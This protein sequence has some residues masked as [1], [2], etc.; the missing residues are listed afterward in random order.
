[1]KT[2]SA[3]VLLF[4]KTGGRPE[5]L[6]VHPGGPYWAKKDLGAWS[7]PKGHVLP[8]EDLF[9]A[10]CREFEEETGLKI[11]GKFFP[12]GEARQ[13]HGKTVTAWALGG[14]CDA[15]RIKS[16]MFSMEWPPRSGMMQ[17]FPE[18]DHGAWFLIEEALQR[19]LKHQQIFLYALAE[20]L[21]YS[22]L[23]ENPESE[24]QK[25]LF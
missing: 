21:G 23:P 10:A 20:K 9:D 11:G 3:G 13:S 8:H 17:E 5:V 1:M 12:L 18:V 6:L 14:D 4:R 16:T 19:I 24:R 22:F 25:P 15:S 2:Q 7:I